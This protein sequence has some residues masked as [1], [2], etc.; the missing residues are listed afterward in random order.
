MKRS[1]AVRMPQNPRTPLPNAMKVKCIWDTN[2]VPA[3]TTANSFASFAFIGNGPLG[4][5]V[6]SVGGGDGDFVDPVF[7]FYK[8]YYG[9]YKVTGSQFMFDMMSTTDNQDIYVGIMPLSMEETIPTTRADLLKYPQY[10]EKRFSRDGGAGTGNLRSFHKGFK[11]SK[12]VFFNK[13]I[14]PLNYQ[15]TSLHPEAL[16]YWCIF[17]S[18]PTTSVNFG[19][20][21]P[22]F[23]IKLT[24]YVEFTK[25]KYDAFAETG[26]T[27]QT[28]V[29]NTDANVDFTLH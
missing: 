9:L 7:T 24:F 12:D 10:R 19:T 26:D 6:N 20:F 29:E 3:I 25:L 27:A 13:T 1:T 22:M 16:W 11:R 23:H 18:T 8:T 4:P 5:D 15:E 2:F 21:Q 28:F 17:L 14:A